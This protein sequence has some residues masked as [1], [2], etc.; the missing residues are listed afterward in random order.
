MVAL[1]TIGGQTP[2]RVLT[3]EEKLLGQTKSPSKKVEAEATPEAR[4]AQ[5]N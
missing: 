3:L 4:D 1:D 2:A 5:G